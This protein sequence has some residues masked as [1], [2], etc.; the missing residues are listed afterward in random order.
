VQRKTSKEDETVKETR[1]EINSCGFKP[2]GCG[3]EKSNS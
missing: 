2:Q 3:C 1:A